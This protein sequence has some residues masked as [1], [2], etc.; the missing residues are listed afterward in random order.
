MSWPVTTKNNM[1]DG[2]AFTH[3]SAHS[4]FPGT[5]GANELSGGAPAYARKAVTVNSSTGGIRSLNASIAFDVAA[6]ST[7]R[8]IGGWNG[9]TFA[10]YFANGG[11]TPKNFVAIASSDLIYCPSHGWSD[12]QKVA[13]VYGTAPTGLTAG[14]VY[15]VR[16]S[17]TDSFKLAATAGGAALDITGASS[18]GCFIVAIREDA[19]ATQDTH[20]V[21]SA[22]IVWPD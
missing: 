22:T 10:G 4:G 3:F 17:A 19:Y 11:A 2:Q 8:Y 21:S 9:S 12:T 6:G 14:T 16:D 15:F 5:T 7:V 18:T 1:L 20:T 13:F